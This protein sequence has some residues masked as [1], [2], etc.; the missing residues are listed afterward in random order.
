MNLHLGECLLLSPHCDQG[1]NRSGV[2]MVTGFMYRKTHL[3]APFV[4][5]PSNLASYKNSP[6]YFAAHIWNG[7]PNCELRH[8]INHNFS[9]CSMNIESCNV[10]VKYIRYAALKCQMM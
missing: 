3:K 4:T 1:Q 7:L 9:N 5:K 10:I 6:Y 8:M 2:R